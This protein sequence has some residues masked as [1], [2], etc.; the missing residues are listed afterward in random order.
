MMPFDA[1]RIREFR[2][3]VG[4]TQ[5]TLGDIL[6]VPQST[7]ARWETSRIS[8]NAEHIGLMC[9][10]GRVQSIGPDFFFPGYSRL[11]LPRNQSERGG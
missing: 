3:T 2:K 11:D 7:V 10:L 5:Q 8:P 1:S 9:D 6:N 4:M